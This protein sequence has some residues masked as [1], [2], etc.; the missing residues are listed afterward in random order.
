[1]NPRQRGRHAQRPNRS[2]F[3]PEPLPAATPTSTRGYIEAAPQPGHPGQI[4][5]WLHGDGNPDKPSSVLLTSQDIRRLCW[6]LH[7]LTDSPQIAQG[8]RLISRQDRATMHEATG[9][10]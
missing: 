9:H 5:V 8:A 4:R 3:Q 10:A 7:G 2:R 1:M 6:F